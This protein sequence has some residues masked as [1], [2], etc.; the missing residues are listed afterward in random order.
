MWVWRLVSHR[1]WK[2][3]MQCVWEKSVDKR[4]RGWYGKV[5]N[6]GWSYLYSSPELLVLLNQSDGI[7]RACSTHSGGE[8]DVQK[9][10]RKAEGKRTLVR[11]ML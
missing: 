6:W 3:S 7:N 5:Q 4:E 8:K 1:K 2:S 10:N 9:F 11:I